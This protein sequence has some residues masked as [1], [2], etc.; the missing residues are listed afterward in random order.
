[1]LCFLRVYRRVRLMKSRPAVRAASI[2]GTEVCP[3]DIVLQ[4]EFTCARVRTFGVLAGLRQLHCT[5]EILVLEFCDVTKLGGGRIRMGDGGAC[6]SEAAAARE[7]LPPALVSHCTIHAGR[8]QIPRDTN[9]PAACEEEALL[10]DGRFCAD[11]VP[12]H[13]ECDSQGKR[14]RYLDFFEGCNSLVF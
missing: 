13:D 1:M 3:V 6:C 11:S 14:S 9:A 2:D 7:R 10:R 12:A 5:P 4:F 8:L